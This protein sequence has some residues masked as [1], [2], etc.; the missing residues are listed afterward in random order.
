VSHLLDRL[1]RIA[2]DALFDALPQVLPLASCS[3]HTRLIFESPLQLL[4]VATCGAAGAV[5]QGEIESFVLRCCRASALCSLR[6]CMYLRATQPAVDPIDIDGGCYCSCFTFARARVKEEI[7]SRVAPHL[8]GDVFHQYLSLLFA[9]LG[10][11]VAW[12]QHVDG[13]ASRNINIRVGNDVREVHDS[14][15]REEQALFTLHPAFYT[16]FKSSFDFIELLLSLSTHISSLPVPQRQGA[17]MSWLHSPAAILPQFLLLPW[18]SPSTGALLLLRAIPSRCRV[19]ST[20][21]HAPILLAF[22]AARA[23]NGWDSSTLPYLA[24]EVQ[25]LFYRQQQLENGASS[26][27]AVEGKVGSDS[28]ACSSEVANAVEDAAMQWQHIPSWHVTSFILKT[29]DD[30]RQEELAMQLLRVCACAFAAAGCGVRMF[31]YD[32]V[33]VAAQAGAC[34]PQC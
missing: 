30:L 32:I 4:A 1:W 21:A 13:H 17:L 3:F 9:R 16:A 14:L 24:H 26:G 20:H 7:E 19:I 5:Q 15:L 25:G 2:P 29:G 12:V 33:A 8:G 27:I 31:V 18:G 10:G 28:D 23:D 22:E 6:V 34:W 11:T